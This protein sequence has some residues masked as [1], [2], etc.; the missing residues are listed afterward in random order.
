MCLLIWTHV[1]FRG[2][3][4]VK[5]IFVKQQASNKTKRQ[6]IGYMKVFFLLNLFVNLYMHNYLQWT[7]KMKL[8]LCFGHCMQIKRLSVV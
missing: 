1:W 6:V 7:V 2:C 8:D 5:L 4:E 3:V